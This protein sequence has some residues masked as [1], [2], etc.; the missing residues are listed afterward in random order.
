M[1]FHEQN[2]LSA[3]AL[4][5]RFGSPLYVYDASKIRQ[6]VRK[7]KEIPYENIDI[8]FA[9]MCNNNPFNFRIVK[10]F[11][12]C[13]GNFNPVFSSH[14]FRSSHKRNFNFLHIGNLK[15]L[16]IKSSKFINIRKP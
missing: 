5:E 13:F 4:V 15:N 8:Y 6:N 12:H 1:I 14:R 11:F 9:S 2:N 7:F 3:R 10:Q 16:R